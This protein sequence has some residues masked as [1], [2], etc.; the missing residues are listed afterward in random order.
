LLLQNQPASIELISV[1]LDALCSVL[2]TP[3]TAFKDI[4]RDTVGGKITALE[5]FK[6]GKKAGRG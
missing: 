4:K 1:T 6:S 5:L 2:Y 3:V